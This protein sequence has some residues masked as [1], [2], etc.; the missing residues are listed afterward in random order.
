MAVI[1]VMVGAFS[2]GRLSA[3]PDES[4]TGGTAVQNDLA[5]TRQSQ[6]DASALRRVFKGPSG[7]EDQSP[8]A[9][10]DGA[11]VQPT[12][13]PGKE[14]LVVQEFKSTKYED[15]VKTQ[16]FLADQSIATVI[17][18]EGAGYRLYSARAFEM[19]TER[20]TLDEFRRSIERYGRVYASNKYRGGYKFQ[21]CYLRRYSG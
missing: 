19:P 20:Q 3:W 18:A 7:P 11:Q 21:G 1:V 16:A 5:A 10:V 8:P 2:A 14:Y 13:V 15:A 9:G 4:V 6:A 17:S 12:L